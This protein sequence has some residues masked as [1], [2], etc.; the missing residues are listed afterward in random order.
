MIYSLCTMASLPQELLNI[1]L[2]YAQSDFLA[3]W[4]QTNKDAAN[5]L[6]YI[7]TLDLGGSN[8]DIKGLRVL[9]QYCISLTSL[10]LSSCKIDSLPLLTH[11]LSSLD[12]TA[13]N[14]TDLN[15]LASLTNLTYLD[16]TYSKSKEF[17]SL[18]SLTNLTSLYM[19]GCT[20]F[21]KIQLLPT[22]LTSLYISK[23]NVRNIRR[24]ASFTNLTSLDLGI[25]K[26]RD[27][28]SLASLTNLTSLDLDSTTVRDIG[29][30]A[31]LTNLTSLDLSAC[32]INDI[33]SLGSLTNLTSL[34]LNRTNVTD[35]RNLASFTNLTSLRFRSGSN[36]VYGPGWTAL[37]SL[38]RSY[39]RISDAEI[40]RIIALPRLVSLN[41]E[42]CTISPK[43]IEQ[44]RA[45]RLASLNLE[46][47]IISPQSRNNLRF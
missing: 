22:Q 31:S 16:L 11:N 1:I 9:A 25:N 34:D 43:S 40:E 5:I 8:I 2:Q 3:T 32:R 24:L 20:K 36:I 18:Q 45:L 33:Q 12:L 39:S 7:Q 30:L 41:L 46:K 21:S 42:D 6:S 14:V 28:L 38:D 19:H 47:C 35:L 44:I 13:S 10:N 23:T 15:N 29:S 37:T 26:V 17:R 4:I 27:I